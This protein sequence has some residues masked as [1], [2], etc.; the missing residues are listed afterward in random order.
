MKRKHGKEGGTSLPGNGG[1][2]GERLASLIP[3][4]QIE[5]EAKKQIHHTLQHDFVKR[6]VIL[7]DVHAGYDLPVG[8]AVL[9]EGIISPSFVGYDIGCGMCLV[10]T[11]LGAE[12]LLRKAGGASHIFDKIQKTIPAGLGKEHGK[13]QEVRTFKSASG[14]KNLTATINKRLGKQLGTLGSGNHF[15]ELG[16]SMK[17]NLAIT[18]HSGSRG[19]GH[20]I[21]TAYMKHGNYLRLD[22]D[23]G[24]S[25]YEDMRFAEEFALNNRLHMMTEILKI[26]ELDRNEIDRLLRNNLVNENHNHALITPEGVLH[27]KGATPAEDGVTGVIP[28][29]MRDG[30]FVT[31]G[32]GNASYLSS[33]SHGAGRVLSR[34]AARKKLSMDRFQEEMRGIVA[35]T[36]RGVLDESPDAY[37]EINGVLAL[38]QGIVVE[39][40]DR[41]TPVVNV[42]G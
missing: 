6:M 39:L 42:K 41:I 20:E 1:P 4:D 3:L 38:Q 35:R 17:G 9:T 34:S 40:I 12:E 19:V 2:D 28:A 13:A 27:R 36:D 15:I 31:K 21:C 26:L 37:K 33:A 14:D 5:P 16:V 32:L 18:I 23:T 25:Y 7:P 10:D 30:V 22:Q 29:N 8:S 24:R 11:N